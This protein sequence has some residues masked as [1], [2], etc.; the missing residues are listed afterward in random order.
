MAKVYD[1]L[2]R[3]EEERK[4]L[5]GDETSPIAPLDA[6]QT[7]AT[8]GAE[9]KT[10]ALL[11]R[12]RSGLGR[13]QVVDT[14][15]ETNKRRISILQPDSHVAEQFRAL[16]GRLDALRTD[17]PLRTIAVSSPLAGEGKTTSAI[18][19][20]A[21]NSHQFQAVVNFHAPGTVDVANGATLTFNNALNLNGHA[22]TKTGPGE[23]AINNNL[24]TAGGTLNCSEG[25]CSGTG[26]ISGDL[27]N[28][29]G[30]I[31]PGNSAGLT[32]VVPEPNAFILAL[33]GSLGIAGYVLR[34]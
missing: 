5:S 19:L 22:L 11:K 15:A 17:P 3:A 9:P 18:N 27:T 6:P 2:R 24:L 7:A 10:M 4:R 21:G 31:S 30:T 28:S 13:R 14:T 25:M 8:P 23:L 16:R 20:A 26:T 12:V 32:T 29:G 34:C 33:L 1:A